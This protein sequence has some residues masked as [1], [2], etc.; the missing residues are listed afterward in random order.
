M[1]ISDRHF[2][3]Y[4]VTQSHPLVELFPQLLIGHFGRQRRQDG[5]R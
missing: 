5:L 1:K 3:S 2:I 4:R